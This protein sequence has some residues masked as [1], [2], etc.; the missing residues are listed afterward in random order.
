MV[1]HAGIGHELVLVLDVP[2]LQMKDEVVNALP[3]VSF[4]TKPGGSSRTYF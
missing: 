3:T 2:V 1:Q 4:P